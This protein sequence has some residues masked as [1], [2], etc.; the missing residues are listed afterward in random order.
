MQYYKMTEES[1]SKVV[2]SGQSFPTAEPTDPPSD[3][4]GRSIRKQHRRKHGNHTRTGSEN[5]SIKQT[6][7]TI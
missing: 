3:S 7:E 4:F 6:L 5:G 2:S 1:R